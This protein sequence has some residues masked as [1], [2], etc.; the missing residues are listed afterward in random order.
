MQIQIE[1]TNPTDLKQVE[2]LK[3]YIERL[4]FD[5]IEKIAI[6]KGKAL[7]GEMNAGNILSAIMLTLKT[8]GAPIA[9]IIT[10]VLQYS[11]SRKTEL[12]VKNSD[13]DEIIL[14]SKIKRFIL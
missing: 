13:G 4:K 8:A 10:A 12:I 11:A 6:K 5:E 7:K 1:F 2:D 3:K 9:A 14:N